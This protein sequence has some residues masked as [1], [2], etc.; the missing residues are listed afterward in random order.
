MINPFRIEGPAQIAFSGGRTSGF[1]LAQI[2]AAHGGT[3]PS[4]V[5]VTFANTG[6]EHPATL[7]FVQECSERWNVPIV[8][9]EYDPEAEHQTRIVNHNSAS[10]RGEPFDAVIESRQ[11]LP[12]P[13]A[14]FCT[15]DLKI[16]R[17][18]AFMR[19]IKG[20]TAWSSV[21]GLRADE[22]RRVQ[23]QLARYAS[24]KDGRGFGRPLMPMHAA[25][26]TNA[27]VVAYW[28]HSPFDLN[29]RIDEREKTE[30][31][32][33][34]SCLRMSWATRLKRAIENP[35]VAQR[36]A[37]R[38]ARA[39]EFARTP[40]GRVFVKNTPPYAELLRQAEQYRLNPPP[41]QTNLFDNG[42]SVD[43]ACTD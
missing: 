6:D 21:V 26:M 29:L 16:K 38:E 1:M 13:V 33:C 22:D 5:H 35:E 17:Q 27:D 25:G 39:V 43:C 12:N 40:A 3:L 10:R 31:G 30:W 42:E 8:W 2:L 7:D 9:L 24:G 18:A 15:I 37:A 14:L 20:Y 34:G 23:K 28:R 19:R 36:M 11:M 4:D 32:N 41:V